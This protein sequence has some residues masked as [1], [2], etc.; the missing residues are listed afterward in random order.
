MNKSTNSI[1]SRE[2]STSP[3]KTN[4]VPSEKFLNMSIVDRVSDPNKSVPYYPLPSND[5]YEKFLQ[6]MKKDQYQKTQYSIPFL[7]SLRKKFEERPPNMKEIRIPLKNEIRSRAKILTD[8]AFRETRNYLDVHTEVKN[9]QSREFLNNLYKKIAIKSKE[10]KQDNNFDEI[11]TKTAEIRELLNKISIDNYDSYCDQILKYKYDDVLLENFKNLIYA[12][13][14]TE[15][16]YC[17]LYVNI[18][19]KM[20]KLYNKKTYPNCPQMVY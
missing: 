14:V 10:K 7:L 19:Y 18:C 4:F 9:P 11:Y 17:E 6:S 15:K 8:E 3:N 16:N 1:N 12:K 20:F 13:A 2:S 5:H